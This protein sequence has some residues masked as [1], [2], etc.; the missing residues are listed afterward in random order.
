MNDSILTSEGTGTQAKSPPKAQLIGTANQVAWAE[1]I[2]VSVDAEF[3]RV[4]NAIRQAGAQQNDQPRV[5]TSAVIAILEEKRAEVMAKE[6]A[7][8]FI[9][10]WQEF[11]GQVRSLITQDPRYKTLR[12]N[13]QIDDST[14]ELMSSR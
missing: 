13:R 6:R 12:A 7:G 3:D 5:D 14:C 9:Q 11:R 8:Y 2:R 10:S 1:Q 4:A